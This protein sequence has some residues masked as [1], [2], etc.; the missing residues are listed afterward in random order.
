MALIS[1]HSFTPVFRG[2]DRPWHVGLLYNRDA[3]FARPLMALLK[4]E[5]DLVVGDNEPYSVSDETDYAIPVYGERRGLPH[6]AIEI[7]Q[8]LIAD[9]RRPARLGGAA[10]AAAAGGL[11]ATAGSGND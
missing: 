1:M 5:T 4:R 8:D 2:V 9:R 10:R 11:S 3:R 7:R 6:I